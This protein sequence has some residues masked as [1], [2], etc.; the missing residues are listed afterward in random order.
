RRPL[1]MLE[2][3]GVVRVVGLVDPIQAHADVLGTCFKRAARY[4][5]LDRA[6]RESAPQLTLILSPAHLHCRQ[7][8]AALEQGSHV[9]CEKPMAVRS[10]E[11]V[12]MNEVAAKSGR[13]LAIGMIRRFF[14]AFAEFRQLVHDR[15]LGACLRFE[16][17]EGHKFEWEVTTPA[18]F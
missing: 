11:C 18:A 9:L 17:R 13:I 12:Q 15:R 16:Y 1:Q 6:L 4:A 10:D 5:D 7:T 3:R 14:P 8:I 2:R